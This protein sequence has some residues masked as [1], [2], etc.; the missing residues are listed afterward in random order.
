VGREKIVSWYALT[1]PLL[2]HADAG[3][4][5]RAAEELS[6]RELRRYAG[7]LVPL[8]QDPDLRV[9][10]QAAFTLV[11]M[12]ARE[13]V[14]E[15]A[16]LLKNVGGTVR[17]N[18]LHVL[19][20]LGSREHG[21]LLAPLLD[22]ADPAIQMAAIQV[23]GRFKAREYSGKIAR[24]LESADPLLR[25]EAIAAL[26]SMNAR[27]LA[28]KIAERLADAEI[29]VRW[30]SIR[31]LGR[32]KAK[33]HAGAIVAMGDEDGAQAPLLEAL[34]ELGLRELA[35]HII[36]ML[37]IPDPGIRW[38][39]V[40]AL[41]SVD[42]KDDAERIAK[43]LKDEDNYVRR[44]ALRALA[45]VGTREYAGD[46]LALLRDEEAEVC[47]CAAE[48]AALLASPAQLKS[49]EPLLA[50]EDPFIRWSALHLL[51][52]ADARASLP[53]IVA[54]LKSGAST[55][56]DVLWAMGR[57]DVKDQMD[58]V[59]IALRSPEELVRQ[60]AIF[61]LARLSDRTEELEGVERNA[62]GATKLAAGFALVR[63]GRKD[64]GA[65]SGLLK[66]LI[67]QRDEPDYQL[68]AEEVFDALSAGFEKDATTALGKGVNAEKRVDTVQALRTLL[69]QAGVTLAADESLEL[70]RRL[71]I[72]T[73][74]TARRALEW[75]VGPDLRLVPSGG[76]I[77]VLEPLRALDLWQK[78][79]DAP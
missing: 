34:G 59:L 38:R 37:E 22:D 13:R 1:L 66:E 21:P 74:L 31:A 77:L 5:S 68:I 11:E 58:Q 45:A 79:L 4:R 72:G 19:G 15:M 51:V 41:G 12:E 56:G 71:P 8:L 14:P 30:E 75:C 55:N 52:A 6:R 63:L 29:L 7:P 39:A 62:S 25:Q 10:W 18:V 2:S 57:M 64:R 43:M 42:A 65:A 3:V 44:C 76:K 61:A 50:D 49:V 35:P 20:R 54:R 17:L 67:V 70:V 73:K 26:G 24:Y 33:E 32:L 48:E 36:P 69:A 40:K 23:L 16:P 53:A 60:Q 47:E 9:S 46:M 28:G 27:D 78:R